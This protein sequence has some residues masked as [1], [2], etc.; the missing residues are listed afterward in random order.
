[1]LGATLKQQ[2]IQRIGQN[3]SNVLDVDYDQKL[4]EWNSWYRGNVENFHEYKLNVNGSM[5][6]FNKA[7]LQMAKTV[8]EEMT[9]LLIAEGITIN[10]DE[11]NQ[12]FLDA[13]LEDNAFKESIF[14]FFEDVMCKGYGASVEYAE[15]ENGKLK[16]LCIDF[17]N[18]DMIIPYS[19]RNNRIQGIATVS[20]AKFNDC[21]LN[22]M[23]TH[24]YNRGM[25]TKTNRLFESKS[26]GELGNEVPLEYNEEYAD[27]LPIIEIE[28]RN[29]AF[30]FY[31]LPIA[32][33]LDIK[34]PFA[35]SLFS[36]AIDILKNIDEKYD[37]YRNEFN[38]GR[39][40]IFVRR[41]TVKSQL[42][43]ETGERVRFFDTG[44]SIYQMFNG[45]TED[46]PIKEIDMNLRVQEHIN[47]IN[48][49]LS[50]LAA[51]VGLDTDYFDFTGTSTKTATEVI[52]ENSKSFRTKVKMENQFTRP[53]EVMVNAIFELAGIQN[54]NVEII[55]SNSIIL[56]EQT[57]LEKAIELYREGLMSKY[58]LQSKFMKMS[59]K[60]IE[61]EMQRSAEEKKVSSLDLGNFRGENMFTMN[62]QQQE[63]VQEMENEE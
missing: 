47:A 14:K 13:V 12:A 7:S 3:N 49:E 63:E 10:V 43:L 61:E 35:P 19:W 24:Y 21:Y 37:S 58:K 36:N 22:L 23:T 8:C 30:Q 28:T 54:E 42:D 6:C 55:W 60:E 9:E 44:E 34:A 59:D 32:N 31:T 57:E 17:I 50:L 46:N 33:N 38:L 29:P 27:M 5:K 45:S 25:Y 20:Q 56:D 41:D 53:L 18:A 26:I 48:H 39:K 11:N 52:S 1:M 15:Y 62:R 40:R 16:D 4:S 2:V 51:K